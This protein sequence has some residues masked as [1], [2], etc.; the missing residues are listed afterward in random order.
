MRSGRVRK[1][2]HRGDTTVEAALDKQD[3]DDARSIAGPGRVGHG[4]E[5]P[6]GK[7]HAT[8]RIPEDELVYEPGVLILPHAGVLELSS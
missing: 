6:D 4:E 2:E 7:M 5:G 3:G 1:E 8:V